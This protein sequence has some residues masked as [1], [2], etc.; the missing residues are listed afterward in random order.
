MTSQCLGR[1][2]DARAQTCA[3]S[4]QSS[5]YHRRGRAKALLPSLQLRRVAVQLACA[6]VLTIGQSPRLMAAPASTP[7]PSKPGPGASPAKDGQTKDSP[8]T[9]PTAATASRQTQ[10]FAIASYPMEKDA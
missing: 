10:K 4:M 7:Q 1:P 2:T 5:G 6:A 9:G 8:A 3:G